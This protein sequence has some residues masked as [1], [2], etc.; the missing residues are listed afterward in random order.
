MFELLGFDIMMD[1][2]WNPYLLEVNSNP[3]LLIDNRLQNIV[4]PAVLNNTLKIVLRLYLER[5]KIAQ[6]IKN[7]QIDYYPFTELINEIIEKEILKAQQKISK[8]KTLVQQKQEILD[9]RRQK[10]QENNF[11]QPADEDEEQTTEDPISGISEKASDTQESYNIVKDLPP[12]VP[13]NTAKIEQN[14][15]IKK[16]QSDIDKLDQEISKLKRLKS[17]IQ[18]QTSLKREKS[19]SINLAEEIPPRP[20]TQLARENSVSVETAQKNQPSG[21]KEPHPKEVQ[22]KSNRISQK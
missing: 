21:K 6:N 12:V 4:K 8:K 2:N 14:S 10:I 7:R 22:D 9:E 17:N 18:S 19:Q 13:K 15:K 3:S 16:I 11:F 5:D 20:E 1:Q